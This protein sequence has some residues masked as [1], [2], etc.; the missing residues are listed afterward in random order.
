MLLKGKTAVISGAASPRGIGRATATLMAEH[1]ARGCHRRPDVD[2]ARATATAL[3]TDHIGVACNVADLDACKAAAAEVIGA[4]GKV[5]ILC[6]NAG[7][8]QPA[9]TLQSSQ[10]TGTASST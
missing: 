3:G 7:I 9:K 2:Q 10:M 8:T 1:G 4:F 6:N 5:D